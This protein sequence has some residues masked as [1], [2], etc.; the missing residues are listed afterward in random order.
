MIEVQEGQRGALGEKTAGVLG[1]LR[2]AAAAGAAGTREHMRPVGGAAY[3][4]T[5]GR[6]SHITQTSRD[7]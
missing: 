2:G 7:W 6:I 1:S 3:K 5:S 4:R